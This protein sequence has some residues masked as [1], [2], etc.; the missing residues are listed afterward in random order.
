MRIGSAARAAFFLFAALLVG[1]SA[2][3]SIPRASQLERNAPPLAGEGSAPLTSAKLAPAPGS[4]SVFGFA[5]D[6]EL[7]DVDPRPG[8]LSLCGFENRR[9][10]RTYARNN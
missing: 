6:L 9:C 8:R 3:A 10:E 4:A 5:G 2:E 1:P 7:L